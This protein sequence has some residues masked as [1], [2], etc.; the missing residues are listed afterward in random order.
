MRLTGRSLKHMKS[1]QRTHPWGRIQLQIPVLEFKTCDRTDEP[2]LVQI[3]IELL[4]T[5]FRPEM[6]AF[7]DFIDSQD[8]F[9]GQKKKSGEARQEESS[10]NRSEMINLVEP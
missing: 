1:V 4:L 2:S 9:M 7:R 10:R 8:Q 6:A 5:M 3:F